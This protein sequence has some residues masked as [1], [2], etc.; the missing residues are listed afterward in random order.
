MIA[1]A[2]LISQALHASRVRMV[3]Q[4]VGMRKEGFRLFGLGKMGAYITTPANSGVWLPALAVLVS[5]LWLDMFLS[6]WLMVVVLVLALLLVWASCNCLVWMWVKRPVSA[7]LRV[8]ARRDED[9]AT[10]LLLV[11]CLGSLL[12]ILWTLSLRSLIDCVWIV[13][14]AASWTKSQGKQVSHTQFHLL[15]TSGTKIMRAAAMHARHTQGGLRAYPSPSPFLSFFSP[16]SLVQEH[17][18]VSQA[19]VLL[20]APR[21]KTCS[22]SPTTSLGHPYWY[23]VI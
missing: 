9:I 14:E 5:I 4:I 2:F 22:F 23:Y 18:K 15:Y 7:D 13:F 19:L 10:T 8:R 17:G 21:P 12:M 1:A 11:T 20:C 16:S 6:K 3:E